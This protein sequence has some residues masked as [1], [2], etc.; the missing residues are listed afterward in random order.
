MGVSL[1]RF[2]GWEPTTTYTYDEQGRVISSRPEPEWD[3]TEREW[4]LALADLRRREESERC[5]LCGLPK[6]VCRSK[7]TEN[8]VAVD[9]ERCHVTTAMAKTR[10]EYAKD[11]MPHMEGVDLIPDVPNPFAGL[12]LGD[13]PPQPLQ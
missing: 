6:V 1:K 12:G 7:A 13:S 11:G 9:L 4:V 5:H 2:G 3:D 10:D 8:Q